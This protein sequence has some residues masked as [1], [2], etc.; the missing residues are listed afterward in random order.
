MSHHSEG[1]RSGFRIFGFTP[2]LSVEISIA[3]SIFIYVSLWY[4]LNFLFFQ[5]TTVHPVSTTRVPSIAPAVP[6]TQVN[7]MKRMTP[8]MF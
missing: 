1:G 5:L 7:R 6:T 8:K 2:L 3:D 4:Y